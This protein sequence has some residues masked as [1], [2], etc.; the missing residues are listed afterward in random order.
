[1][2]DETRGTGATTRQMKAAPR[3]AIFIW[4]NEYLHYPRLLARHLGREDLHI[5][6][7]SVLDGVRLRGLRVPIIVDH[8]ARLTDRQ[9]SEVLA[10]NARFEVVK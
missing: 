4:C 8:A 2:L 6:E 10:H 3:G 9:K 7:K 5:H 1:M